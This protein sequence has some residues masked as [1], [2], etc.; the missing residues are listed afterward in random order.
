MHPQTVLVIQHSPLQAEL[1]RQALSSQGLEV[2][3]ES[4]QLDLRDPIQ[5]SRPDLLV[6]DMTSGLFN[7]YAFCREC[8]ESYPHIPVI[9]THQAHR[10]IEPAERRWAIYQGAIDL[11][12]GMVKGNTLFSYVQ[13]VLELVGWGS[14][15]DVQALATAMDLELVSL[16]EVPPLVSSATTET[17]VPV[18]PQISEVTPVPTPSKVKL[19]FR[20]RPVQSQV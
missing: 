9:L 1:W 3:V 4:P 10:P 7:P 6:V 18:P 14:L 8:R 11:I 16:V 5:N 13:H 19:M 20:G 2:I 17:K 12:P 15:L